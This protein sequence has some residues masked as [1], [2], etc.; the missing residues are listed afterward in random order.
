LSASLVVTS[1]RAQ[2]GV[3]DSVVT[4]PA[5][6]VIS[7]DIIRK[8]EAK[9]EVSIQKTNLINPSAKERRDQA[10]TPVAT[11]PP[12]VKIAEPPK[13]T[14]T[15]PLWSPPAEEPAARKRRW[16]L[17]PSDFELSSIP[18]P[19]IVTAI[20]LFLALFVLSFRSD[21]TVFKNWMDAIIIFLISG[22]AL[23][24]CFASIPIGITI[25]VC[26]L[27]WSCHQS[28]LQNDP[29][30]GMIVGILRMFV[31]PVILGLLIMAYVAMFT[32][33]NSAREASETRKREDRKR[34]REQAVMMSIVG[35]VCKWLTDAFVRDKDFK[36]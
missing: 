2:D 7:K 25:F 36:F 18:V 13:A 31:A 29:L 26:G 24:M 14:V 35:T 30:M 16:R 12:A 3:D 32:S 33:G 22:I 21:V 1:L 6:V 10:A 8:P 9:K 27:F 23:W 4:S 15:A 28:R 11:A 17:R 5:E 20:V 19:L 34:L